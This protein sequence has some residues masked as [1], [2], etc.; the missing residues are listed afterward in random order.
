MSRFEGIGK[1]M[2]FYKFE[3]NKRQLLGVCLGV[4]IV[5]EGFGWGKYIEAGY[6]YFP[7]FPN[8]L[9]CL[10]LGICG[11]FFIIDA[12]TRKDISIRTK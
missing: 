4:C 11:S 12:V 9:D 8:F 10:L 3:L 2:K 5:A 7:F 1:T 6:V